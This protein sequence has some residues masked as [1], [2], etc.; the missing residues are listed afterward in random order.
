MKYL[1]TINTYIRVLVYISTYT[2]FEYISHTSIY[3]FINK[4][5]VLIRIWDI[6][7]KKIQDFKGNHHPSLSKTNCIE[8]FYYTFMYF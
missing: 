7:L 1:Q 8:A 3:I 4:Q 6:S 5:F 2:Y